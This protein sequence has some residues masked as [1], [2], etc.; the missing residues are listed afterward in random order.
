MGG[1]V[2]PEARGRGASDLLIGAALAHARSAGVLQVHLGVG[3][4]NIPA[5]QLYGR[6]GFTTYGTQP[7]ALLVDGKFIDEHH[8]MCFL[9]KEGR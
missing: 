9:D 3:V 6:F 2:R 4:E 8:M 5:Q 1:Y 7:R